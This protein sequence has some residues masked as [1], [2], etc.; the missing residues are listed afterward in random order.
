ME[1]IGGCTTFP[2]LNALY[3]SLAAAYALSKSMIPSM[4]FLLSNKVFMAYLL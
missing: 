1:T 4:S 2:L 3:A